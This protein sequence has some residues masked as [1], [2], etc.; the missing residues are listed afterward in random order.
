MFPSHDPGGPFAAVLTGIGS[1]IAANSFKELVSKEL[2]K[3][4]FFEEI[5]IT[6]PDLYNM[7]TREPE[8]QTFKDDDDLDAVLAKTSRAPTSAADTWR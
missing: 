6:R 7:L 1:G 8:E 4:L 3:K 5:K 2:N